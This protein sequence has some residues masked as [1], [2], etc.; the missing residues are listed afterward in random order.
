MA[1]AIRKWEGIVMM[2]PGKFDLGRRVSKDRPLGETLSQGLRHVFSGERPR[3]SMQGPIQFLGLPI[4]AVTTCFNH[5]RCRSASFM[6]FVVLWSMPAPLP[7]S[8]IAS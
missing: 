8:S 3:R 2:A 6:P 5:S 4:G 7:P 1:A